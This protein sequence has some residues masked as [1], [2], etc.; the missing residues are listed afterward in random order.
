M[1]CTIKPGQNKD[2]S[3]DDSSNSHFHLAWNSLALLCGKFHTSTMLITIKL[4]RTCRC[5]FVLDN[6][7]SLKDALFPNFLAKY[8][9][10][11]GSLKELYVAGE[12][13]FPRSVVLPPIVALGANGAFWLVLLSNGVW[14]R[15]TW[16]FLAF[17]G[18]GEFGYLQRGCWLGGAMNKR[19]LL[20]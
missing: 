16:N 5:T 20:I 15:L 3:S 13:S 9:F 11:W 10:K 2:E 4:N 12:K 6:P 8:G 19:D 14:L 18:S 1:T 17:L 7:V